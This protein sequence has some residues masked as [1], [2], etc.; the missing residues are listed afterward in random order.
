MIATLV[1]ILCLYNSGQEYYCVSP[2]FFLGML[3]FG[4][5]GTTHLNSQY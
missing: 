5:P 3:P 2:I 1:L 4:H